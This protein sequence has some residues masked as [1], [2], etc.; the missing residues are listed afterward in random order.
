MPDGPVLVV[1]TELIPGLGVPVAGGGLRAWSIGRGLEEAG[2]EVH[3]SLP[4]RMLPNDVPPTL[5]DLAHDEVGV[6]PVVERIGASVVVCE[7]W[8]AGLLAAH[9][10]VPVVIDLP[11]PMFMEASHLERPTRW[12]AMS[13]KLSGLAAGDFFVCADSRQKSYYRAWL[14]MAGVDQRDDRLRVVPMALSPD[15]PVR[16]YSDEPTF[17]VAGVFHPWLNTQTWLA[18]AA[19]LLERERRGSMVVIGGDHPCWPHGVGSDPAE[20]L[21]GRERTDVLGLLPYEEVLRRLLDS[22]VALDLTRPSPERELAFPIRAITYLWCG[23][24]VVHTRDHPLAADLEAY[25]CGWP[26]GGDLETVLR[27]ILS[28]PEEVAR[29]GRN[30]QRLVREHFTW[31]E[32]IEPLAD[33]CRTPRSRDKKLNP[34]VAV[35]R[36]MG[37]ISKELGTLGAELAALHEHVNHLNALLRDKESEIKRL[38]HHVDELGEDVETE[39]SARAA[40]RAAHDAERA[41]LTAELTGVRNHLE[42]IRAS[43]PYRAYRRLRKLC[44]LD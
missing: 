27:H 5:A 12:E 24:G 17:A 41:R 2:L 29:K 39:R 26:V 36:E 8:A 18:E 43:V 14:G 19:D 6:S 9:V 34:A 1:V 21:R 13:Y 37:A 30:A 25:E 20:S 33:F 16:D 22:D 38:G 28:S 42:R 40:E 7:Q 4:K 35:A 10:S 32:A 44:G 11:G 31:D 15:L 3:F 23:L